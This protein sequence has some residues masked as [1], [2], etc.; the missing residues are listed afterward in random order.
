M[1]QVLKQKK[2][3]FDAQRHK[4]RK[5]AF[6]KVCL[7]S[8]VWFIYKGGPL[9]SDVGVSSTIQKQHNVYQFCGY[10]GYMAPEIF[11]SEEDKSKQYDEKCDVFSLGCLIYELYRKLI[12]QELLLNLSFQAIM[13][14]DKTLEKY[15]NQ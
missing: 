1:A 8:V 11:I 14:Y 3:R 10:Y 2:E 4:I 6:Q 12:Q 13:Y 5:Y 15:I 7:P 9:I